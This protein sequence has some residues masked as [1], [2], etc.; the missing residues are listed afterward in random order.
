MPYKRLGQTMKSLRWMIWPAIIWQVFS[1]CYSRLTRGYKPKSASQKE[2]P[3]KISEIQINLIKP[4][5][6]LIGFAALVINDDL[7]LSGIGIH[8][9]LI[10]D[11]YRI[12]YP[13]R[14]SGHRD[15]AIFHP[16]NRKAGQQ[17]ETAIFDRLN[18]VLKT[19]EKN[20]AGYS[21]A[22]IT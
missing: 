16:I 6:G 4:K 7:Y 1:G 13:T 17:I 9:K 2:L 8:Q 14:K 5:E 15:F 18:D 3:V 10:G 19:L 12:T 22:D 20:N 11:G 21:R